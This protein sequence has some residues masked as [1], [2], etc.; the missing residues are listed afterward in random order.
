[1]N[2]INDVEII[3][4]RLEELS[5]E[6]RELS[7]LKKTLSQKSRKASILEKFGKYK[8]A[9]KQ[10]GV[11]LID[12]ENL[13]DNNNLHIGYSS[14]GLPVISVAYGENTSIFPV[15]E[16]IED[17]KFRSAF[18]SIVETMSA[19]KSSEGEASKEFNIKDVLDNIKDMINK[20]NKV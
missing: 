20:A 8:Y 18:E 13:I 10:T 3:N 14:F 7:S 17:A 4:K 9:I 5:K 11:E 16:T 19:I 12:Y 1:M 15:C 6:F 2:E